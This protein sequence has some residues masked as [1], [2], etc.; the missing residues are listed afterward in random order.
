[1]NEYSELYRT[2]LEKLQISKATIMIICGGVRWERNAAYVRGV[3][4]NNYCQ[5]I[6]RKCAAWRQIEERDK[7]VTEEI[8][9]EV[10]QRRNEN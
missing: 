3:R 7:D 8:G 9:C 2:P 6:L 4:Y 10:R 5:K 1:M